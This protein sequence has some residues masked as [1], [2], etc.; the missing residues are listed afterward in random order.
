[1]AQTE[2]HDARRV[3]AAL[4][5]AFCPLVDGLY[6]QEADSMLQLLCTPSQHRT[7][8]LAWICSSIN[9]SF[10]ESKAKSVGTKDPDVL[11]K[12]MAKLGQELMLCTADDLDLIRGDASPHRQLQFLDQLLTLVPGCKKSAGHRPNGEVLLNELFTAENLPHLTG[13]LNP[14]L[15]PWPAHIKAF[16]K[17]TTSSH[18]PIREEAA[19]VANELQRTQL[20]L[21]KLRSECEFLNSEM[22]ASAGLSPSSLRV[23]ACD[24]QQ[25]IATYSRVYETDLSSYCNR[26]PPS[27]S[28][29]AEVFQRVHQLLLAC[30]TE[31][32]M[33]KEVSETSASIHEK[34][35]QLQT[36]PRHWSRG[37]KHRLLDKSIEMTGTG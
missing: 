20:E 3:Y 37:Q 8:I 17:G 15:N 26:E 22:Q 25:L 21:E 30:N 34:A 27:F 32:D 12:E 5:A 29:D 2:K 16:G 18:R 24:L 19:D 14:T 28:E 4:Q 23:A 9:P 31:L 11:N 13:M 7:D 33:L 6:L 10:A 36:Q 35:K 1:M